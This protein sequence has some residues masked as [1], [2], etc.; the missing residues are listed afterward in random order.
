MV[1]F[2]FFFKV[3]T[4]QLLSLTLYDVKL[5]VALNLKIAFTSRM[6]RVLISSGAYSEDWE[7]F[8]DLE[9]SFYCV[10]EQIIELMRFTLNG[11]P[12]YHLLF[13]GS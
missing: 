8:N 10:I 3:R 6:N 1:H 5:T 13:Y 9:F 12:L 4:Q 11:T 2:S 7:G